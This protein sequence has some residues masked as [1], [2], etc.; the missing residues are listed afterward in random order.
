MGSIKIFTIAI[1]NQKSNS[2]WKWNINYICSNE[3]NL[4]LTILTFL[5]NKN[6]INKI[7]ILGICSQIWKGSFIISLPII[8]LKNVFFLMWFYYLEFFSI[9]LPAVF[10]S[11]SFYDLKFENVTLYLL[12]LVKHSI[13]NKEYPL[14]TGAGIHGKLRANSVNWGR[15][16]FSLS[17]FLFFPAVS[18]DNTL[19][20]IWANFLKSYCLFPFI[21]I[22]FVLKYFCKTKVS[23]ILISI[24]NSFD[25]CTNFETIK[26]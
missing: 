8:F 7:I 13:L 3:K 20:N 2:L 19:L 24:Y 4:F 25:Y 22:I 17:L 9:K 16:Q 18:G 26:L 10:F 21:Q 6:N 23:N 12:F 14:S 15:S 1:K 11:V 5:N